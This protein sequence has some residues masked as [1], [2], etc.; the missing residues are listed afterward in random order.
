MILTKKYCKYEY[1]KFVTADYYNKRNNIWSY[2]VHKP[3]C[4]NKYKDLLFGFYYNFFYDTIYC[5]G[6]LLILGL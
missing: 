5:T 4:G 1:C 3:A 6:K 2:T